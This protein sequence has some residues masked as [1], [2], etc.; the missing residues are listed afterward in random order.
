VLLRGHGPSA[1]ACAR[2][3]TRG[4]PLHHE[5][6]QHQVDLD[7]ATSVIAAAIEQAGGS[8]PFT[9]QLAAI[10]ITATNSR[11]DP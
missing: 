6:V 10:L 5:L 4:T 3:W 2:G 11:N 7:A 1:V 9:P 8:E